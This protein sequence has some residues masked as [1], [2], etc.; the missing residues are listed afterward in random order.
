VTL[1]DLPV[2]WLLAIVAA[3]LAAGAAVAGMWAWQRYRAR[4]ALLDRIESVAAE[5]LQDVVLP[6]GAG[7][8]FH[9]DFL[10]LTGMGL[11]VVDLRDMPGL[12]F[13]S[14]QMTEWTVMQKNQ[15]FTFPNPL[16]SLYDRMAVVRALVGD[17]VPVE[18]RVVFTDRGSFPKGHPRAVTRLASLASEIPPLAVA[19][20]AELLARLAP[21]WAQV[22]AAASP[23]PLRRR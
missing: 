3:I 10:L 21:A 6:D 23:S 16:G 14:E 19:G 22:K 2:E 9:V 4:R 5:Y 12:I 7:G 18:G 8:W 17:N 15:R 13:G 1:A 20:H 11:V